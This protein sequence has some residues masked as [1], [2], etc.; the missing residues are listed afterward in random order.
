MTG[1]TTAQAIADATAALL[2][3]GEVTDLLAALI[4][5]CADVLGADAIGILVTSPDGGTELL[6]ATSH[7]VAELELYQIQQQA[8]PCIDAIAHNA[9][10]D[11]SGAAALKA[12]WP[13]IGDAIAAAGF[14]SVH[15]YP[16]RWHDTAI[17]AM[18]VFGD[19]RPPHAD[20]GLIGQS[21]ADIAALVLAHSTDLT[22]ADI[23]D[24]IRAALAS[25]TLIEQAKGALAY[26]ERIEM[27]E[28]YARLVAIAA[29]NGQPLS[30][31]A[32]A[33]LDHARAG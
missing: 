25:R 10:Q 2:H 28:A 23:A 16:I 14:E 4:R 27:A 3:P 7:R 32:A 11:C 13:D 5:D 19:A 26:A 8:G 20:Q 31:V 22:V 21:F 6:S 24:R 17:G 33:V 12:R 18:N 15:A 29:G 30:A 9:A 1:K